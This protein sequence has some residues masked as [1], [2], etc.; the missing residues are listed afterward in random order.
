MPKITM[1]EIPKIYELAKLVYFKK[2]SKNDALDKAKNFGMNRGSAHDLIMNFKYMYEGQKYSR[3]N[4]NDTTEYYLERFLAD[5]GFSVLQNG[6]EAL[7]KHIEYYENLRNTTMHG[8]RTI[9]EKY[10]I[11]LNNHNNIIYPDEIENQT[12]SEGAKKQVVVNAYERNPKARQECI[13]Y[14]GTKCNICNFDFE[15]QYGEIGKGFIH[16]HHIK[17]LSEINEEYEVNPIQDLRP[18]CPNCHAMIHKRNPPYSMEEIQSLLTK[19]T[20][21][22]ALDDE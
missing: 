18:V 4:N 9:L 17:P 22:N 15:K 19:K 8:L 21:N 3:T 6:V 7:Q 13:K 16:I 12:L 10:Q 11:I 5:F 2:I 14:Y 1:E 20:Y